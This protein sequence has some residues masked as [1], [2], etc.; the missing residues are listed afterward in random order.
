VLG[1]FVIKQ[2]ASAL[3]KHTTQRNTPKGRPEAAGNARQDKS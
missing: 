2:M 1:F 3:M